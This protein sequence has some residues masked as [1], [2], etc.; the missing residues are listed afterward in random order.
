[1]VKYV[2]HAIVMIDVHQD[3]WN[4]SQG[5][6]SGFIIDKKNLLVATNYHVV[7]TA[8]KVDVLFHNGV[9]FGVLGYMAVRPEYDLAILKLNGSPKQIAE[10][11]L[12]TRDD[13]D[14]QSQVFAIGHPKG[15][16]FVVT[17]GHINAVLSTRQLPQK[18]HK[19]GSRVTAGPTTACG[20]CTARGSSRGTAEGR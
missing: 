9:R 2:Q 12:H 14:V 13:P 17:R 15:F 19:H 20:C 1:M 7:S 10:L 18:N 11:Q 3:T 8:V 6:G 5:Q 16:Q 4:L